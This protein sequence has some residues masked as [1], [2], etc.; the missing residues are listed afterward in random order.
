MKRLLITLALALMALQG[1]GGGGSNSPTPEE[2]QQP[3]PSGPTANFELVAGTLDVTA[4]AGAPLCQNGPALGANMERLLNASMAAWGLANIRTAVGSNGHIYVLSTGCD[5]SNYSLSL[6]EIDPSTGQMQAWP[7]PFDRLTPTQPLTKVYS[8]GVIA[9]ASDGSVLITDDAKTGEFGGCS[10][11]SR[12]DAV[13]ISSAGIWRFKNGALSKVAGFDRTLTL[14]PYSVPLCGDGYSRPD[15]EDGTG[16][17]A[18]FPYGPSAMCAGPDDTFYAWVQ[19]HGNLNILKVSLDGVVKRFDAAVGNTY[20]D[21]I[22]ATNRRIFGGEDDF[23]FAGGN[24]F[25]LIGSSS[26][27][28]LISGHVFSQQYSFSTFIDLVPRYG[29]GDGLTIS[30]GNRK[31]VGVDLSF[32]ILTDLKS[33]RVKWNQWINSSC[34]SYV[35]CEGYGSRD[36]Y[37]KFQLDA[38]PYRMPNYPK[39]AGIDDN[40]YAYIFSG[41]ALLRYKLPAE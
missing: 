28:E 8:P 30:Y 6:I 14:T 22:C 23:K 34:G 20:G 13:T 33:Q 26:Y 15:Y 39:V 4:P 41:N 7:V 18:L 2:P 38:M 9:V 1:C 11:F 25:D 36:L 3:P 19:G 24:S 16:G 29:F 37:P 27:R 35:D 12:P 21:F 32:L 10:G 17:Q 31:D 5:P 40:N